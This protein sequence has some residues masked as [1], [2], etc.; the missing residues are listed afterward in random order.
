ME[1]NLIGTLTMFKTIEMLSNFNEL[2]R[3]FGK[4]RHTIKNMYD[5]KE[6]KK[7]KKKPSELDPHRDEIIELL[8]HQETK[9]KALYWYFK[10]EK[11]LKCTYDN[12]KSFVKKNKLLDEAKTGV[13][14]SLFETEPVE[15]FQVDCVESIKL[16]TTCG[17][18]LKFNLFSATLGYSMFH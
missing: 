8:S 7:R 17:E 2:A 13:I 15:Q 12:F 11:Q 18:I 1:L 5:G 3:T 4:G 9:V 10:N 6:A 14:H 16:S